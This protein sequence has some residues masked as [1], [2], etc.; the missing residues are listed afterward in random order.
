MKFRYPIFTALICLAM[1]VL[2]ITLWTQVHRGQSPLATASSSPQ[3]TD[4]QPLTLQWRKGAAQRYRLLNNSSMQ[5]SDGGGQQTLSTDL[6]ASLELATLAVNAD[7]VLLGMQLQGVQLNVNGDS[8]A[9][10]NR[11]LAT[12]FRVSMSLKGTP[13]QFEFPERLAQDQRSMLRELLSLFQLQLQAGEQ[14]TVTESN[15][16]GSYQA[17]YQR[18]NS[19]QISKQKTQ[20]S[21]SS[22][23]YAH[24]RIASDEVIQFDRQFDW[25]YSMSLDETLRTSGQGGPA[26]T[27]RNQASLLL[28]RNA[29]LAFNASRWD[30]IAAEPA[31]SSV[32]QAKAPSLS[33]DQARQR[34]LAA[35]PQLDQANQGR[36]HWIYQLR[37]WLKVDPALPNLI[38]DALQQDDLSDRTR[39]DLY[40]AL[41]LA[42]TEAAQSALVAVLTGEQWDQ[43]DAIR[44]IVALGGIKNPSDQTLTTL[45]QTVEDRVDPDLASTATLALGNIAHK[46][47][48]HQVSDDG[49]SQYDEIQQRLLAGAL[50]STGTEFGN[51][52]RTDYVHALG[53]TRDPE[54]TQPVTT[55]LADPSP[56]VRRAAALS[57][58]LLD[59]DASAKQLVHQYQHES[60][61]HVR[62]AIVESLSQWSDPSDSSMQYFRA[63]VLAERDENTRYNMAKLLVKN[64]DKYPGNRNTLKQLLRSEQSKR[65][66][67]SVANQLALNA[68]TKL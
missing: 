3:Q 26:V 15:H 49:D 46:V 6:T 27:I 7:S 52:Q 24:A 50:N 42:G 14:W 63:Q 37:D 34:I 22:P 64:I 45:W 60:N 18:I 68:S 33:A 54:L 51:S 16:A 38:L 19:L 23:L 32:A 10:I 17:Q 41:E 11:A 12:P 1:L 21:S 62:G 44:A 40:L 61:R 48:H 53:N 29:Q 5:M 2:V 30:F 57:L 35:L 28:E 65:I 43:R 25:F 13:L 4:E 59:T 31:H 47:R 39:A 66:R 67:Q 58:A 36:S 56:S 9:A 20:L 8:D 55:L